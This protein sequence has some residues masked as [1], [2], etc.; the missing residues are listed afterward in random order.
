MMS[1]WEK[2][3]FQELKEM[4]S[5]S[6]TYTEWGKKMGYCKFSNEK[7][8]PIFKAF[9]ELVKYINFPNQSLWKNFS[10]EEILKYAYESNSFSNFLSKLGYARP[11]L[12]LKNSIYKEY[13]ELKNFF[14]EKELQKELEKDLT[15]QIFGHLQVLEKDEERTKL[16]H[17]TFWKCK[18]DCGNPNILSIYQNHLKTGA[19]QSCGCLKIE[20]LKHQIFG[21]LEPIKI[22]W[23]KSG[24]GKSAYWLC[25]CHKCN[26]NTLK[27]ISAKSLKDGHSTT[28]GCSNISRGE[29]KIKLILSNNNIDFIPQYSFKDCRGK[30]DSYLRFDFLVIWNDQQY[31]IE[32]Q[33]EQHFKAIKVWGGEE[34]LLLRQKNDNIKR[35][36]CRKNNIPL[37]EINYWDYN[38]INDNYLINLLNNYQT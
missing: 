16:T 31:L 36:Y 2:F 33:G 20:D 30:N 26:S 12:R 29:E 38:L 35:E 7:A 15:G 24:K 5:S 10:K 13:P 11:N 3:S 8:Q 18:C 9:P 14:E 21:F 1:K 37:I 17:K 23:E 19:T 22:D 28:C 4:L 6:K 34:G 27:S 25:K 32:Y